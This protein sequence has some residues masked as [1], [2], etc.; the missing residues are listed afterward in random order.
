MDL[1]SERQGQTRA[2]VEQAA[3]RSTVQGA[4]M[5]AHASQPG[6]GNKSLR[7]PDTKAVVQDSEYTKENSSGDSDGCERKFLALVAIV[8]YGIRRI[9]TRRDSPTY[10][11]TNQE[12]AKETSQW[13]GGDG[14]AKRYSRGERQ[15][16][17]GKTVSI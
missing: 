11:R 12:K 7:D 3:A 9:R 13:F 16:D 4:L 10:E 17:G 14:L 15:G 6:S 8:V 5:T 1:R 2:E